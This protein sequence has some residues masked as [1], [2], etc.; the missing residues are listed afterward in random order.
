M[1]TQSP[2]SVRMTAQERNLIEQAA[3]QSR[4]NLSDFIRRKAVEA[5]ELEIIDRRIVTIPA[6]DWERFEQWAS[7]PAED[8]PSLRKQLTRRPVWED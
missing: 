8:L 7:R 3:E 2:V 1:S 5:A 4:T 6:K